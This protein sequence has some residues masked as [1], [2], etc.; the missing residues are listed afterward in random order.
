MSDLAILYLIPPVYLR[1]SSDT[2]IRQDALHT[3]SAYAVENGLTLAQLSTEV[4]SNEITAIPELLDLIDVK[5]AIVTIDAMG[6]QKEIARKIVEKGGDYVLALKKNHPS[7]HDA[8]EDYFQDRSF[9]E[10]TDAS[11][12]S[13]IKT[14]DKGHGRLE[15][16]TY[17]IT[18]D[19][20]W[21]EGIS[22][23]KNVQSIGVVEAKRTV[24]QKVTVERR[25]FLATI[26]PAAE[27]LAKAVRSHWGIESKHWI[28]DVSFKEDRIAIKRDHA[29]E[30][31]S[32]LRKVALNIVKQDKLSKRS[33]VQRR[34]QAAGST[35]YLE[36]V[37]QL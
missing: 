26:D 8:V 23:W 33:F 19:I 27:L 14:V 24:G 6:C 28:L 21:I 30:N 15:E 17:A 12:T 1:G 25:Y 31:L 20:S 32:I 2:G 3:V 18:S 10:L 29:P 11:S 35:Q 9:E 37:L 36:K 13:V 22:Q 4:K 34:R 5:G 7:L 16:R